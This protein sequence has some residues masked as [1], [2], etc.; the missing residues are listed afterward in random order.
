M[1]EQ[2]EHALAKCLK[3][4]IMEVVADFS[5]CDLMT[6]MSDI[7]CELDSRRMLSA[8]ALVDV[9]EQWLQEGAHWPPNTGSDE[10]ARRT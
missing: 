10:T 7:I 5:D 2:R 4:A 6:P 1:N 3:Q 9:I 8:S